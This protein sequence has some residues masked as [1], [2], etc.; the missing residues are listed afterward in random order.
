MVIGTGKTEG[1]IG[2]QQ[3]RGILAE[4]LAKLRPEGKKVLVI[5]PDH[6]RSGPI[7]LFFKTFCDL[8][9]PKVKQ[10][11]FL[12]ALG[13][14]PPLGPDKMDPLLGMNAAQRAQRYKNVQVY[15]H[16]WVVVR[17]H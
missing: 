5:L 13:T 6:T 9:S 12:I 11:N 16:R 4:G 10:L 14:H 3:V 8:L 17:I 7:P 1:T 15:N 2:A